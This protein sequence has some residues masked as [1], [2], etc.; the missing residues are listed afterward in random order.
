M[1]GSSS[2]KEDNTSSLFQ[3]PSLR[4]TDMSSQYPRPG[5]LPNVGN[6]IELNIYF[7]LSFL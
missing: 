1:D 4:D 7:L 3:L 6:K 5:P 2:I